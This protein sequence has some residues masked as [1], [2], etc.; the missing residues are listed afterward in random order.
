MS[1]IGLD[2]LRGYEL[3]WLGSS[4]K[5]EIA[6]M[7]LCLEYDAGRDLDTI[8]LKKY[9]LTLTAQQFANSQQAFK[10][11]TAHL[12]AMLKQKLSRL[13][14]TKPHEF[15]EQD[16]SVI[17]TAQDYFISHNVRF[18]CQLTGQPSTGTVLVDFIS[19]NSN[20]KVLQDK[21]VA[22]RKSE[23]TP[24][25]YAAELLVDDCVLSLH[26]ARKGGFSWQLIR[27]Y[28]PEVD[29]WAYVQRA[30]VE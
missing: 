25:D 20:S 13:T 28:N 8:A 30:A 19:N 11:I 23:T 10:T 26:L 27:S 15:H 3:S 17:T 29:V 6:C 1:T 5:P 2:V 16:L 14:F 4:G 18:I 24:Q 7:E 12:N 22:L 21:I 9:F